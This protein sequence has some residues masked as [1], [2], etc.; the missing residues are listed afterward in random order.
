MARRR[1]FVDCWTKRAEAV[2]NW[3]C[4]ANNIDSAWSSEVAALIVKLYRRLSISFIFTCLRLFWLGICLQ[5]SGCSFKSEHLKQYAVD[6]QRAF[7]QSGSDWNSM[8][9]KLQAWS[10]FHHVPQHTVSC[11]W[12][13]AAW[14]HF[15]KYDFGSP[16]E[17]PQCSIQNVCL[18]FVFERCFSSQEVTGSQSLTRLQSGLNCEEA[19]HVFQIHFFWKHRG[20]AAD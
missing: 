15:F 8:N 5:C 4:Q 16:P 7:R 13:P 9:T 1:E 19:V 20:S 14:F 10:G 11:L 12:N 18:M 6:S 3:A 17:S 2:L